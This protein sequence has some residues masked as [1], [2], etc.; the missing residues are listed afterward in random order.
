[1]RLDGVRVQA[2]PVVGDSAAVRL[3]TPLKPCKGVTV[4]TE[5]PATPALTVK[6]VGL[7]DIVKS[8]TTNATVVE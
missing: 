1:V 2:E 8:W 4:M 5:D 3:T 7:A 6:L